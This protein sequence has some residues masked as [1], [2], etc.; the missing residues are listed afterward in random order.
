MDAFDEVAS[1]PSARNSSSSGGA[2]SAS[3]TSE[4]VSSAVPSSGEGDIRGVGTFDGGVRGDCSFGVA[5]A[6]SRWADILMVCWVRYQLYLRRNEAGIVELVKMH[7]DS[8]GENAF[9]WQWTTRQNS[10]RRHPHVCWGRMT[11][12]YIR[13]LI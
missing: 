11:D 10:R 6:T 9:I 2:S 12:G 5:P 4:V 8:K 3:I 1:Q 13:H 7:D